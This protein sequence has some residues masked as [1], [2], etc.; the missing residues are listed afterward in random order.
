[1]VEITGRKKT[2]TREEKEQIW[3]QL[4][5]YAIEKGRKPGWIYHT[6]MEMCG[7]TPKNRDMQ[8]MEPGMQVLNYIRH[9]QIKYAKKRGGKSLAA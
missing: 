1:M 5:W 9:K 8:P 4:K 3:A 6:C 2:Y 7:S